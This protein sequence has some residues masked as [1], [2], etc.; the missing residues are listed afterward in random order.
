MSSASSPAGIEKFWF[1]N[2]IQ[3]D[4]KKQQKNMFWEKK[5]YHWSFIE[6][7]QGKYLIL[8]RGRSP[9]PPPRLARGGK[10]GKGEKAGKG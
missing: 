6:R 3:N 1:L 4:R 9:A 7:L 5:D 10:R 8:I 2:V